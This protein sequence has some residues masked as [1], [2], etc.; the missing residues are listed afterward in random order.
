MANDNSWL[1]FIW[2]TLRRPIELILSPLVNNPK[3]T[4]DLALYYLWST[5]AWILTITI[6]WFF[7]VALK[8][9]LGTNLVSFA[10]SRYA[11]MG[12]RE[13]EEELNAKDRQPIGV[14]KDEMAYDAKVS[15]LIDKKDDD[16]SR[17]GLAGQPIPTPAKYQGGSGGGKNNKG[18]ESLMDVSRYTMVRSRIW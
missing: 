10:S 14:D 6:A 7:L 5:A 2:Q 17:M 12:Q 4:L 11:T 9:I 15:Q 18:S 8:L 3:I 13:K 16:A 1:A